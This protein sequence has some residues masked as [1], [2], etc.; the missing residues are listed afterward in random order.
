MRRKHYII[1]HTFPLT[2]K[3]LANF[4]DPMKKR[5]EF[6]VSLRQKK[7]QEIINQKRKRIFDDQS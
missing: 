4:E 7:K 3:N 5:E 2:N 6:S 1:F